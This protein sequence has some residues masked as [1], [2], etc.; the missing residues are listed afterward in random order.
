M[1]IFVSF[2]MCDDDDDDGKQLLLR[3]GISRL[4]AANMLRTIA[5]LSGN[6]PAGPQVSIQAANQIALH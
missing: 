2:W 4:P 3:A 5:R 6:L 1:H